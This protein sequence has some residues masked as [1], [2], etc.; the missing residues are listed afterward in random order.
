MS[1]KQ[2]PLEWV[3]GTGECV[4]EGYTLLERLDMKDQWAAS[5]MESDDGECIA[6]QINLPMRKS[7]RYVKELIISE[8]NSRDKIIKDFKAEAE[9]VVVGWLVFMVRE[10]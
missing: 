5:L 6:L 1:V 3:E 2:I 9:K 10:D 7:Q 8:R 4:T